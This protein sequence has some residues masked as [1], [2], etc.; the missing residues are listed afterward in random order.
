MKHDSP[1]ETQG[2][3][4]WWHPLLALLITLLALHRATGPELLYRPLNRAR[5]RLAPRLSITEHRVYCRVFVPALVSAF[6]GA[7]GK[8]SAITV[9]SGYP[10]L[11]LHLIAHVTSSRF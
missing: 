5:H 11:L 1:Y 9:P 2:S 10:V 3:D 6:R 7:L 8:P 4:R